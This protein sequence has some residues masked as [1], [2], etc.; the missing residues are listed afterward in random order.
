M[1]TD[2][3]EGVLGRQGISRGRDPGGTGPPLGLYDN[4]IPRKEHEGR[5]PMTNANANTGNLHPFF[6]RPR[7]M[8]LRMTS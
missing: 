4:P 1:W 2:P 3:S 5:P 8:R 6:T 7:T